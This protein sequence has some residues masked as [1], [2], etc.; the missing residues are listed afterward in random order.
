MRYILLVLLFCYLSTHSQVKGSFTDT[1]DGQSY[2]TV[3]YQLQHS[4]DSVS[5][6]TWMA[7]N[8]NFATESSYC[9]DDVASNCN[10]MGRLYAWSVA[11]KA[12]PEGWRLPNDND[13]YALAKLY[14]GVKKAGTH[15]KSTHTSWG[16]GKGTNKSGFNGM[17]YG[18]GDQ[19]IKG[20]YYGYGRLVI[21]WSAT[22]KSKTHAWD[23]KLL[24]KD[25]F[26]YEGEKERMI[27]CVRC[28]K[29]NN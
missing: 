5:S 11:M 23:W 29:V 28:V 8:L 12:C 26:R 14:G 2:A 7:Q 13:W 9:Y 10:I 4:K 27:N 25:L 18:N 24:G 22:E 6:V 17:P 15:L 1:R 20:A 21:F 19:K 16:K 3:S